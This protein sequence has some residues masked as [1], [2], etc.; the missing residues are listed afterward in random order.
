MSYIAKISTQWVGCDHEF[1]IE[2]L[3]THNDFVE[4]CDEK[5]WDLIISGYELYDAETGKQITEFA[6]G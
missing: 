3:P 2:E 4:M 5:V 1:E 6:E